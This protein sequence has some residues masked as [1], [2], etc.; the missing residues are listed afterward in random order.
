M[1]ITPD[2]LVLRPVAPD[3]EE[4]LYLVYCATRQQEIATWGWDQNQVEMFLRMQFRAQ[5]Q[6]YEISYSGADSDLILLNDVPVGRII[7]L[8]TAG[9]ILG[10]DIALL[11]EHRGSGIGSHLIGALQAEAAATDKRFVFQVARTNPEAY[12]L[13]RRLG[14]TEVDSTELNITMEWRRAEPDVN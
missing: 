5:Q 2:N 14:F 1:T 12:R 4:F 11:P 10:V 8:R 13:Y 9:E 7:V 3:D 6:G